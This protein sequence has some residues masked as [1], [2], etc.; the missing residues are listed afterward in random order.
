M[1][2]N[3]TETDFIQKMSDESTEYLFRIWENHNLDVWTE[4]QIRIV[5]EILISRGENVIE[6]EHLAVEKISGVSV[7]ILQPE[8]FEYLGMVSSEVVLGTGLLS[9]LNGEVADL[10]GTRSSK[11]QQKLEQARNA[12]HEELRIKTLR[13]GG[14]MVIG[15]VF[16][17]MNL[18]GN[19]IMVSAN[20]TAVRSRNEK[21]APSGLN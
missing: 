12:A 11:F 4:N 16:N 18:R 8:L 1:S 21:K 17:Y 3:N 10:F 6:P 5:G 9:E 20:G 13:L 2:T 19:I 15:I 7:Q 14:D